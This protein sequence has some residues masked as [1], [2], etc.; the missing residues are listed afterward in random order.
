[1]D[2]ARSTTYTML[3]HWRIAGGAETPALR[4]SVDGLSTTFVRI[5]LS[6]ATPLTLYV[7]TPFTQRLQL[8]PTALETEK[9]N[10]LN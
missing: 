6:D 2:H 10:L 7:G 9:R 4:R 8:L 1:M 5:V 3:Q